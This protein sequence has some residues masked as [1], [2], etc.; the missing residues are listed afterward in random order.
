[1]T[2]KDLKR[3]IELMGIKK[4]INENISNSAIELQKKSPNGKFYG[5]VRENKKYFIKES[6]DGID[7][8]YIGGLANKTKNQYQSYEEAVKR[9]NIMFED[10][11]RTYGVEK[12]N[13]I[14]SSDIITEK[15]FVLKNKKKKT[16]PAKETPAEEEF[17]FGGEEGSEEEFDFGGEE[18]SEEG[19]E[20]EFDFGGE[21]ET[22][23]GSEEEFDFGGEEETEE[24]SEEEFDEDDEDYDLE[25]DPIKDIQRLTGKL[26]QK[27]RDT[28]D[29]SSDTMKWVVKSVISAL[30]LENMDSNDKK[31]IIRAVKK[32]KS[33]SSDEEFDFMSYMSKYDNMANWDELSE[34]EKEEILS[35]ASNPNIAGDETE[36]IRVMRGGKEMDLILDDEIGESDYMSKYTKYGSKIKGRNLEIYDIENIKNTLVRKLGG[37]KKFKVGN[38]DIQGKFGMVEIDR[39]GYRMYISNEINYSEIPEHIKEKAMRDFSE[40]VIYNFSEVSDLARDI[41]TLENMGSSEDYMYDERMMRNPAPARPKER[42]KTEPG[43]KPGTRP[44]TKP[45]PFTPPPFIE[46]GEEPAPKAEYHNEYMRDQEDFMSSEMYTTCPTC[47][48]KFN[49]CHDCMGIGFIPRTES[50]Y[51]VDEPFTVD[52][53]GCNSYVYESIKTKKNIIRESLVDKMETYEQEQAFMD[54]EE[55]ALKHGLKVGYCHKDKSSDPEEKT[56]YLELKKNNKV[57]GKVRIN[58]VGDIEMGQMKNKKFTGQ[59]VDSYLDFEEYLDE[60][61][62]DMRN[63][64]PA[65]P[66]E[67]PKTE[68]GIKPGTRPG[69]KPSPFTPPP[70]IEP[71]EEPAPKARFNRNY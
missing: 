55:M 58:S 8:D 39:D 22:E 15:K 40:P 61:N 30:D 25:D 7:Y 16:E 70:F 13:D 27:I 18:G 10:F 2:N 57:V 23:E 5:I 67:R 35:G 65:R 66:K 41:R 21:E 45:S 71:G 14:L 12:N 38:N 46:P 49:N 9:L 29:L 52:G 44:G 33:E 37:D 51:E 42:P 56:I 64:A 69:T 50:N 28:E 32:R 11:N 68:P 31:D 19:S 43:I 24:D 60:K 59:P 6:N 20:E 3:M 26:G 17:D 54:V 47:Q 4:P 53:S 62:I 1:M 48:G 34:K 36:P 63:P